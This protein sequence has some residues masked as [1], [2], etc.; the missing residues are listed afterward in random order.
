MGENRS[1]FIL[2]GAIS[3]SFFIVILVLFFYTLFAPADTKTY[4]LEK[5]SF[6]SV[7]LDTPKVQT[8]KDNKKVVTPVKESKSVSEVKEV[9]VGDL[10]SSVPTQEIVKTKKVVEKK[11]EKRLQEP[12]KRPK[13]KTQN[14]VDSILQK[15]NNLDAIVSD[16][17]SNPTSSGD[18]VN[19]YLA[20]IQALVYEQ[21]YPPTNSE[22]NTVKVVIELSAIGKVIDFRI[23][24]YSSNQALNEECDRIKDRL[25]GIIFPINPKNKSGSTIINITSDKS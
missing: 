18:E 23:L 24:S 11:E 3:L 7:S 25:K 22:G 1:Y 9:D 17:E 19:E 13:P 20:K 5:G 14:D 8:K 2:S 12:Q 6:V 4:A 21:F 15:I 16:E 10:F